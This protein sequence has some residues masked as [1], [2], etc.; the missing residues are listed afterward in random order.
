MRALVTGGA[1]FIGSHLVDALVERR[2][3]GRGRRRP[4]LRAGENL[5][6]ALTRGARLIRADVRAANADAAA[7][8]LRAA[9]G[10]LP[11]RRPDR[12]EPRG[13][14]PAVR[15]HGEHR[16]HHRGARRRTCQRRSTLRPGLHRRRALRRRGADSHAGARH[17]RPLSPYGAAKAAAEQYVALYGRLHGVSTISLR[18][19]N[20]YGPRQGASGE[21]GVVARYCRA[22]IAG[23]TAPVYGDGLQT[24][25]FVHVHDVAA[26]FVAAGASAAA[27]AAE[28]RHGHGDDG[29]RPGHESRAA[30]GVPACPSRR[31]P[32]VV[33]RCR[34]QRGSGWYPRVSLAEGVAGTLAFATDARAASPVPHRRRP[35]RACWRSPGWPHTR[36]SHDLRPRFISTSWMLQLR[37]AS[38]GMSP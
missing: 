26:A 36:A 6:W 37:P 35:R 27:G 28:R 7:V 4:L 32:P 17:D 9:R 20:V 10:G 13:R 1:G 34:G 15:C 22:R 5:Q 24:R 29:P 2:P 12:R 31:G 16:R 18:L 3:R 38:P 11:S 21:G 8:A 30:A 33:P 19:A 14:R 23:A 25:D